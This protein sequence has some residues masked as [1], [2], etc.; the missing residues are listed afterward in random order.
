MIHP[1]ISHSLIQCTFFKLRVSFMERLRLERQP[2]IL[3]LLAE[4][5][6]SWF[7][8]LWLIFLWFYINLR[9]KQFLRCYLILGLEGLKFIIFVQTVVTT[10]LQNL[11]HKHLMILIL[12]LFVS[13]VFEDG[14]LQNDVNLC[15]ILDIAL[16]EG[17]V[18]F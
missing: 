13:V 14:M 7:S 4:V 5:L 12:L 6:A 18:K 17:L 2:S 16:S 15:I 1:W 10:V 8:I 11:P 3:L 9:L